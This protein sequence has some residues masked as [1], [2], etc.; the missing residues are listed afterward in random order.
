MGWHSCLSLQQ[1]LPVNSGSQIFR[2]IPVKLFSVHLDDS[3]ITELMPFLLALI[4]LFV[5]CFLPDS[6]SIAIYGIKEE[7]EVLQYCHTGGYVK[8]KIYN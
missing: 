6:K 2:V 3:S 7:C 1:K 8:W 4:F 5:S